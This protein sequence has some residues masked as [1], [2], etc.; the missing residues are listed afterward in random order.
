M[1]MKNYDLESKPT[2]FLIILSEDNKCGNTQIDDEKTI[3]IKKKETPIWEKKYLTIPEAI[4]Y[5]NIGN[6]NLKRL[7]NKPEC[8]FVVY[9]GNR[10]LINRQGFEEYLHGL[11]SL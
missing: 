2:I 11:H 4:K 8:D 3:N 6:N 1:K 10:K 7:L 9:L 5:S